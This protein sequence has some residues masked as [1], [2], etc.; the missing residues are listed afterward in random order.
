MK[1]YLRGLL[2]DGAVALGR[3]IGNPAD[4]VG[5]VP[6]YVMATAGMRDNVGAPLPGAKITH[7]PCLG[8]NP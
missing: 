6:L 2:N 7:A 5:E 3:L 1:N 8:R 4:H